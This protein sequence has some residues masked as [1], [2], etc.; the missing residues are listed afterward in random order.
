MDAQNHLLEFFGTTK[1]PL[2]DLQQHSRGTVALPY[3]GGPDVLAAVSSTLTKDGHLRPR[4]GDSY[5]QLVRFSDEGVEIETVN[6][7]GASARPESP[8]YTDQMKRFTQQQ[9]KPMTLDKE[10]VL[11]QAKRIYSPK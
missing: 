11:Q 3:G 1:V 6:A 7:Y 2:G 10:T 9:L 4:A 8:H 5:I